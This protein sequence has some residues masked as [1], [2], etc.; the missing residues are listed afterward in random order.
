[1]KG[2]LWRLWALGLSLTVCAG[3]LPWV[4]MGRSLPAFDYYDETH[5]F[6]YG[7]YIRDDAPLADAY[8]AALPAAW[9]TG[10]PP[11]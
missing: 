3:G 5:M 11:L 8:G 7:Q 9:L 10:Y 2:H 1:M 6:L 4:L